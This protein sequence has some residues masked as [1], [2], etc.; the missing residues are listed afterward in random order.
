MYRYSKHNTGVRFGGMANYETYSGY[1][2]LN[3]TQNHVLQQELFKILDIIEFKKKIMESNEKEKLKKESLRLELME[4]S[5][6]SKI[7]KERI[8]YHFSKVGGGWNIDNMNAPF[9]KEFLNE[10][11]KLVELSDSISNN[12]LKETI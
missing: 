6:Q 5:K 7:V 4:L 9:M 2:V 10:V 3:E 1:M 11:A 8:H 12:N